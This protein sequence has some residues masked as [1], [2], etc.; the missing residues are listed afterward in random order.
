MAGRLADATERLGRAARELAET[1][2]CI[3]REPERAF[4]APD[5]LT[6]E[7]QR[8]LH[9]AARLE[10]VAGEV[11]ALHENVLSGL[12]TGTL[13]PEPQPDPRPRIVLAPRPAPVRAFLRVR[14]PRATDRI[15]PIL[16]RRRRTPRPAALRVPQRSILGR[17]PPRSPVCAL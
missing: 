14:L 13:V 1:N 17:A 4:L 16:R 9:V 12:A 8:W 3:A 7:A 11:F 10:A 5:L 6:G 2:E 15:A